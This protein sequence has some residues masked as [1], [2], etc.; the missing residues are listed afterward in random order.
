MRATDFIEIALTNSKS[1][2][3]GLI[4]DMR[5]APL[6]QPTPK[7]G[8]HPLWILGHIIRNESDL[9]DG[10]ILG[11][12]NRFPEWDGVF[13]VGSTPSTD[14]SRYPSMD[15]LMTKFEQMR[16]ATLAH[17]HTLG[18][19]DLDRPSHAPQEFGPY[20][21]TVGA[22]FAAISIHMSFHAGQVSDARR[23]AGREPLM[24]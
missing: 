9:L 5:D 19:E 4:S 1:W 20:F 11:K 8:N 7:G 17:L 16:A 15:E 6:T 21:A 10:F 12:A 13:S 23:A 24:A 22:C 18:D 14:A 2:A 3:M